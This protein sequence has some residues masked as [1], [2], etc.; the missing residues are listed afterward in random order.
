MGARVL[1]AREPLCVKQLNF[2]RDH[3]RPFVGIVNKDQFFVP[4]RAL[5]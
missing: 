5:S 2:L 4:K 3:L 1:I